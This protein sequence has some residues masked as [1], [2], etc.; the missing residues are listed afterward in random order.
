VGGSLVKVGGHNILEPLFF[1]KPVFF[2][3]FM[4]N[5]Q[6][7]SDAV[8]RGGAGFQIKGAEEMIRHAKALLEDASLRA[9]MGERGF[10]IIR[11]NRGAT[12]KTLETIAQFL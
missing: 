8:L 2:G 1:K 12:G 11:D 5:F 3:P 10:E 7:I 6:E 4:E 9:N